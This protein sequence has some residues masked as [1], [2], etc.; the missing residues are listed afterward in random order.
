[1]PLPLPPVLKQTIAGKRTQSEQTLYAGPLAPSGVHLLLINFNTA[2]QTRRCLEAVQATCSGELLG[3]HLLDNSQDPTTLQTALNQS[4]LG[5]D[6]PLWLY[7]SR[8]N[9][10]FAEGSNWLIEQALNIA[11]CDSVLLLNNDAVLCPGGLHALSVALCTQ[12]MAGLAGARGAS[13]E[14]PADH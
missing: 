5:L 8:V 6:C 9:S 4:S 12:P 10:G 11:N 7:V 13:A 2:M 1:M 14:Q 3:I